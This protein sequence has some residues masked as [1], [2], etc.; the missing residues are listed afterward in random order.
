MHPQDGGGYK[1]HPGQG[2]VPVSEQL[3]EIHPGEGKLIHTLHGYFQADLSG[4]QQ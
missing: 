4:C 1:E 2:K 3:P